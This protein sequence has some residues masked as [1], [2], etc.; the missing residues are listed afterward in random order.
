L[1]I[2]KSLANA[3]EIHKLSFDSYATHFSQLDVSIGD[4]CIGGS[5]IINNNF[6][7]ISSNGDIFC[8]LNS[9][10][11]DESKIMLSIIYDELSYQKF[12]TNQIMKK[13][14]IM[15]M[16]RNN[17]EFRKVCQSFSPR[18]FVNHGAAKIWLIN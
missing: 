7:A 11:Y 15:C 14:Q 16:D 3:Q 9:A 4:N 12:V 8:I 6:Y 17:A 5:C 1:P 10:Q 18:D 2:L 13:G